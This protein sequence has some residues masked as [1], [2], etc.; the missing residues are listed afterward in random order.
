MND[1][2]REHQDSGCLL[3]LCE[4][5]LDFVELSRSLSGET[6]LGSAVRQRRDQILAGSATPAV[7]AFN[8][9]V[10]PVPQVPANTA[11]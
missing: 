3:N 5:G 11:P 10:P 1:V 6:T 4:P 9:S 2:P 8:N 7:A